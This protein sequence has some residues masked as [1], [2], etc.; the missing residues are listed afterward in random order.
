VHDH[1]PAMDIGQR[2]AGQ[3]RGRHARRNDNDW[4]HVRAPLRVG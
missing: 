4:I 1:R 3:P 2:F